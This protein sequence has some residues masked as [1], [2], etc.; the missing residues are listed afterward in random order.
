[1]ETFVRETSPSLVFYFSPLFMLPRGNSSNTFYECNT[2]GSLEAA[3]AHTGEFP[4]P[5]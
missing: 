1:M 2:F 4:L 3:F 5:F